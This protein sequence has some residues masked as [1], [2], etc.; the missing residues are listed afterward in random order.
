MNRFWP[1]IVTGLS[2]LFSSAASFG[3]NGTDW[4]E[5]LRTTD[6]QPPHRII[7]P[8]PPDVEHVSG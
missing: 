6:V 7:N 4:D 3:A 2:L 8:K 5:I 1:G